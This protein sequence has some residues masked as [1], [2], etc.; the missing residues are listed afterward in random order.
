MGRAFLSLGRQQVD[1][2]IAVAYEID[3]T[4]LLSPV[5][6]P[7]TDRLPFS[8][9]VKFIELSSRRPLT[10]LFVAYGDNLHRTPLAA[11]PRAA[12]G[13]RRAGAGAGHAQQNTQRGAQP[14]CYEPTAQGHPI[15]PS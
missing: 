10:A 15:V 13:S 7:G 3:S 6:S 14:T 12:Q 11:R 2:S 5:T 4:G 8:F 1:T 9:P